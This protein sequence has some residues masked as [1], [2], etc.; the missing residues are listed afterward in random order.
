MPLGAVCLGQ[1][2][3]RD[4]VTRGARRFGEHD[5][6]RLQSSERRKEL[7]RIALAEH[8]EDGNEPFAVD[9]PAKSCAGFGYRG[10]VVAA[11]ENHPRLVR[12]HLE[13]SRPS[14]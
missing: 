7:N 10:W 4:R 12:D 13:A 11:I 14:C 2:L 1:E 6:V 5:G 9:Q 3:S 8:G